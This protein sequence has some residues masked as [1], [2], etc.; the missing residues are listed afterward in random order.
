MLCLVR[1]GAQGLVI[2]CAQGIGDRVWAQGNDVGLSQ[3]WCSRIGDRL[4][5][6][7]WG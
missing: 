4:C 7:D 1:D 2:G 3:G 5:A 6:R